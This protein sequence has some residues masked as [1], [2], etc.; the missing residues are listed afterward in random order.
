LHPLFKNILI[1]SNQCAN[2]NNVHFVLFTNGIE[3]EQYLSYIGTN[4]DILINYNN[5]LS[6]SFEQNNKLKNTLHHIYELGWFHNGK[7]TCGCNL[8]LNEINYLWIWDFVDKYKIKHLRCSV[9]SPGG[10]YTSWKKNKN[11]YFLRMKPIFLN[12]CKEAQKRKVILNLDCG[13]I[14]SCYF[15]KEEIE[16]IKEVT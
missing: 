2:A 6:L 3:L 8:H 1:E 9:V 10:I 12:F 5:F 14:P 13:H 11:E 7:V 16:L 4:I 15:N